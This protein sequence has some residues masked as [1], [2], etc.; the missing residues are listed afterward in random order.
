MSP[1]VFKCDSN[2]TR[3]HNM[4]IVEGIGVKL[5]SILDQTGTD[6]PLHL[7]QLMKRFP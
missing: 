3:V 5:R 4:A 6:T 2:F 1:S 7:L